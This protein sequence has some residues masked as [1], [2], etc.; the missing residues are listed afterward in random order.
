[1]NSLRAAADDLLRVASPRECN[2]ATKQPIRATSDATQPQQRGLKALAVQAL[3]RNSARNSYEIG[4]PESA[5]QAHGSDVSSA[6]AR[7]REARFDGIRTRLLVLARAER[8]DATVIC[9]LADADIAACDGLPV[10]TLRAYVRALHDTDLRERGQRPDD[11]TARALCEHCGPVWIAPEVAAVAP[12]VDG[13]PRVIGC[14]WCHVRNRQTIPR[15][16]HAT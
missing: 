6:I 12:M 9:A 10:E 3:A 2:S 4:Q 13:W 11:E 15:P 7:A 14:P 16:E 5:Q 1:M 8:V